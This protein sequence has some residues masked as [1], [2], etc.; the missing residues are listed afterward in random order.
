MGSPE[1]MKVA[2]PLDRAAGPRHSAKLLQG[3]AWRLMHQRRRR[4]PVNNAGAPARPPQRAS[5]VA[6]SAR[7]STRY[8]CA[9]RLDRHQLGRPPGCA[10]I[11][12]SSRSVPRERAR[13][14]QAQR[15]A[16]CHP[17]EV[18]RRTTR[19]R[20]AMRSQRTVASFDGGRVASTRSH[21]RRCVLLTAP[22]SHAGA[23]EVAS[24]LR[25]RQTSRCRH[26]R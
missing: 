14:L 18:A 8:G 6:A 15:D 23:A 26:R 5:L 3:T 13:R 10:G 2:L 1:P 25:R 21:A 17:I 9:L 22:A 7:R 16:Q 4:A 11:A 24:R 12:H 19:S 20:A